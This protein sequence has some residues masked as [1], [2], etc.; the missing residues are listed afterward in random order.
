[1]PSISVASDLLLSLS[2]ESQSSSFKEINLRKANITGVLSLDGA[3]VSGKLDMDSVLVGSHLYMRD[4]AT[5]CG[6]VD[7]RFATVGL[8]LDMKGGT[9]STL[10]LRGATVERELRLIKDQEPVR[11]RELAGESE[12]SQL[13]LSNT[14]AGSLI[15][16]LES[17]P[18]DIELEGFT[19]RQF[20]ELAN[21]NES[22]PPVD[23][24][25]K[26]IR[27]DKTFSFQPYYQLASVLRN[28]GH[29]LDA[30]K[31]LFAGKDN[32]RRNTRCPMYAWWSVF[33]SFGYHGVYIYAFHV[34]L[35][36]DPTF[37]VDKL[38]S[39][40]MNSEYQK[41]PDTKCL[42]YLWLTVL[43]YGIGYGIGFYIFYVLI[44]AFAVTLFGWLV[45]YETGEYRRHKK[46]VGYIG[47]WFSLD[48]LLPIIRL[49]EA[50]FEKVDLSFQVRIYFY[51]HQ[52]IGYIL[53]FF[54][55]A[56]LTG[57][58]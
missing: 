27:R 24:L 14:T 1:M 10:D 30:D 58:T 47:F 51:F 46:D 2:E 25:I 3:H 34:F 41:A 12:M 54:V 57:L 6:E 52:I 8:S 37:I 11:W 45:L 29:N 19:Y 9:L 39:A 56:G 50:H 5:F 13:D 55:I 36:A 42:K 28:A 40:G 49:R 16:N 35:N 23:N 15:A 18:Q 53:V 22:E 33:R 43:R 21:D 17:W 20:E 26:W 7:L 44:V 48:Y 4:G 32:E 38:F 31:V